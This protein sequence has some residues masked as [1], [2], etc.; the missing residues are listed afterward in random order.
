MDKKI[1][2]KYKA[3]RVYEFRHTLYRMAAASLKAKYKGSALG[4]SWALA[5]PLLLMAAITFIFT[6]VFKTDIK[7]FHLFVLSGIFPWVFFSSSLTESM[8]SVLN[9]R[10]ILRQFN[11]PIEILPLSTILAHFMNFLIGWIIIYPVFIFTKPHI[12]LLAPVLIFI[13]FL[14]FI[15]VCGLGLFFST[16]NVFFRDLE[17]LSGVLFMFWF[18]GTPV[19]YSLDMLPD[20]FRWVCMLNPLTYFIESFRSILYEA[21]LPNQFTLTALIAL[22]FIALLAGYLVFLRFEKYFIKKT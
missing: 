11:I 20:K 2:K 4:I 1:I 15:F 5:T 7:N 14:Y 10:G 18:W 6:V 17:H 3:V 9:N 13:I 19:F 21:K 16:I 22:S 12:V 8:S